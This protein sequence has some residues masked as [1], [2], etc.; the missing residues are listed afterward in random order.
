MWTFEPETLPLKFMA[1]RDGAI[2]PGRL[3]TEKGLPVDGPGD[4][5]HPD[6]VHAYCTHEDFSEAVAA[7]L[8]AGR[9]WKA[10]VPDETALPDGEYCL[11]MYTDGTYRVGRGDRYGYDPDGEYIVRVN[12]K[13]AYSAQS[14][15][16]VLM[17][18]L[19]YQLDDLGPLAEAWHSSDE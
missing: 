18:M 1:L 15:G 17:H 2:T 4:E 6:D 8:D 9:V 13:A 14:E 5:L 11:L 19:V 12:R 7:L 3:Y 10:G 16:T